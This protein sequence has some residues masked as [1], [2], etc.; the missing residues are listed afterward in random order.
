MIAATESFLASRR[1]VHVRLSE[2]SEVCLARG[3]ILSVGVTDVLP[4]EADTKPVPSQKQPWFG[5]GNMR[6]ALRCHLSFRSSLC[7]SL[8]VL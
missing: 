3:C 7:N 4:D 6:L 8:F 2:R 1:M 5:T